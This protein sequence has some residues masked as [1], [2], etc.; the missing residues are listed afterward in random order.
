M[1][2]GIY[3]ANGLDI[4]ALK[5]HYDKNRNFADFPNS[6]RISNEQLLVTECDVLIPA[7]LGDVFDR[8]IA[9]AVNCQYIVEA[10]N[11]PTEPEADE[12]F[13]KEALR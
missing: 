3:S 11:G 8:K 1:N 2:S 7:A 10:A 9:E 5:Q 12:I 13:E 4:P 6:E